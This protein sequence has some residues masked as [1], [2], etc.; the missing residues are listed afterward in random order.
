[1]ESWQTNPLPKVFRVFRKT[2]LF[3]RLPPGFGFFISGFGMI[4]LSLPLSGQEDGLFM[5]AGDSV[6]I[7]T[8]SLE[9][10]VLFHTVEPG[11]TLFAIS[12]FYGLDV[13]ELHFYNPG[14]NSN[15]LRRGEVI[16]IPLP[17]RSLI[18]YPFPGFFA[19]D[20]CPVFYQVKKGD[21]FY[22][23]SKRLFQMPIDTLRNRRLNIPYEEGLHDGQLIFVGWM[24][25]NGIPESY[26]TKRGHPAL[27]NNWKMANK[28]C[29]EKDTQEQQGAAEWQKDS[30]DQKKYLALHNQALIDSYIKV[31]NPMKNREVY[32]RVIGRI[33]ETVYGRNVVVVLS[34]AT[35]RLLGAIDDRFFVKVGYCR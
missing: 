16:R 18:R 23:L 20:H 28:Y 27:R 7:E 5:Q 31:Y 35:A 9:E 29:P 26:R 4:W 30:E 13:E 34:P 17:N 2:L 32:A 1:M 22:G 8:T 33:P 6:I 3:F 15:N 10:K 14:L 25:P 11:Q 24:S 12:Q 19:I 21:T